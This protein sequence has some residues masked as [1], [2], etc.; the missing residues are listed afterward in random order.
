MPG[1]MEAESSGVPEPPAEPSS[2]CLT[3]RD[4]MFLLEAAEIERKFAAGED[5][6]TP[7]EATGETALQ[8]AV[9]HVRV[10][11]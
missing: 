1:G 6:N 10:C 3:E 9:G 5:L 8:R 4:Q 7:D 2:P 11:A